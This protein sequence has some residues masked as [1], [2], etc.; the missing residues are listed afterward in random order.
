MLHVVGHICGHFLK[1]AVG[2][3]GRH[4]VAGR[5]RFGLVEQTVQDLAAD[6]VNVDQDLG[7]LERL[8]NGHLIQVGFLARAVQ[9]LV[10][11]LVHA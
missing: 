1:V 8:E 4:V 7:V 11:C 6:I 10:A 3:D 9:D 2:A 5:V